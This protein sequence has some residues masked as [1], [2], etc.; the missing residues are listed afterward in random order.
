MGGWGGVLTFVVCLGFFAVL[1]GILYTRGRIIRLDELGQTL[2]V[3][4]V[5]RL[6]YKDVLSI[7]MGTRHICQ[8]KCSS[9]VRPF[10]MPM[11][12]FK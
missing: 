6:Q 3:R 4:L 2:I 1:N 8:D 10:P 9:V 12:A 5:I 11:F 7:K